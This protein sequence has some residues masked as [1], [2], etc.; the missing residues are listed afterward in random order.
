MAAA[1]PS[2]IT[3]KSRIDPCTLLTSDELKTIQGE[4]L[5]TAIPS[6]RETSKLIIA[7]C[8]YELPA[9]TKSVVVN[10]TTAKERGTSFKEIWRDTQPVNVGGGQ[11]AG[12]AHKGSPEKV[13]GLGDDA[14]WVETAGALY[15]LKKEA[16]LRIGIGGADDSQTKLEKLKTLAQKALARI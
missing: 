8:Y 12:T 11:P 14:Y 3:L 2:P 6:E 9:T 16:I 15:V 1:S 13:S 4:A 7:Q 10:V 5:R